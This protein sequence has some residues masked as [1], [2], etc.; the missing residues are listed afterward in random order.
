MLLEC[1]YMLVTFCSVK[2]KNC[3]HTCSLECR[4]FR[5]ITKLSNEVLTLWSS[6]N[7]L[8]VVQ[9]NTGKIDK[10]NRI[11]GCFLFF[12]PL[13]YKDLIPFFMIFLLRMTVPLIL[14]P[15]KMMKMLTCQVTFATLNVL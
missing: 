12:S 2:N 3:Y 10:F 8:A 7:K 14:T 9:Y 1:T 11:V 4:V 6:N 5:M 15:V 13:F